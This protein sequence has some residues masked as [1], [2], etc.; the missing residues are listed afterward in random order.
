MEE[1]VAVLGAGAWGTAFSTLLA[2]Q[3]FTVKLWCYEE[4]VASDI[5]DKHIN[6]RYLPDC[7]LD[8][9]I[10]PTTSLQEALKDVRFVFEVVPVKFMRSILKQAREHAT[11]DQIWVLLS[12][13]IEQETHKLPPDIIDEVFGFSP[14]KVT[15]SGPN[16]ARD[17]VQKA[18]TATTIASSNCDLS[19]EVGKMLSCDY[20]RSYFSLDPIGVHVGGAIKNVLALTIGIARGAGHPDNTVAFL[21]TRGMHEIGILANHFGGKQETVYGL[22]GL[23]D[24]VLT[25]LGEHGRNQKVGFMVGQGETLNDVLERTGLIPEGVNTVQ[26]VAQLIEKHSLDLPICQ[27]TY[28]ILFKGRSMKS[29][30]D[31]LMARPLSNECAL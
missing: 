24:L 23:G 31:D 17:L 26:S 16:F 10:K 19:R 8:T 30:L 18:Y 11:S 7:T 20:F 13:G 2:Q 9:N 14:Q 1:C 15:I 21:L 12:K 28:E 6:T 3:G 27:G 5:K 29:V 4:D 25:S 22:S